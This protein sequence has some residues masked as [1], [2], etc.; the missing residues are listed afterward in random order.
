MVG[1]LGG[2]NIFLLVD[3]MVAQPS[4]DMLKPLNTT[5]T[6]CEMYLNKT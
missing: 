5:L 6:I 4:V 1:W 2:V 3:E